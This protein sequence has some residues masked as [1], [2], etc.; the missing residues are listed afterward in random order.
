MSSN[1]PRRIVLATSLVPQRDHAL[2][3]AAVA[4]WR[5]A[6]FAVLSVNGA[7]EA[8]QVRREF[9]D[10]EVIAVERTAEHFAKKPVPFIHD[11]LAALR[12]AC[13]GANL[14]DCTVGIINA[15]IYMRPLPGLA[16]AIRREA[17]GALL[18]GPRVDVA[19][20]AAFETY[21]ATG[22]E[23]YSIGYDYFLMSGDLLDDF[24][25]SPFCMGMPFWDYW[26]PLAALLQGRPL[27]AVTTPVALHVAHETRWDGTIYL[28]FHALISYVIELCRAGLRRDT[29]AASRQFDLMFDA[30]SHVYAGVFE[31]GTE[32]APGADAPAEAAVTALADFYDRFQEVAVHHIK[33]R[34]MPIT[35]GEVS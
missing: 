10:V 14:A 13:G 32:K 7:K 6:G 2:Q 27:K 31:R 30:L 16:P 33:S 11:L 1:D 22:A 12:K 4:S 29:S 25:D 24:A 26:M 20:R 8:E 28:F 35:I 19:N 3:T 5:A 17:K 9:P 18:L 23:T 34:A 21:A 15:D